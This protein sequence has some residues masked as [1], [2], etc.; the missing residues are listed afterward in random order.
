MALCSVSVL[1]VV[2]V[3]C[4]STS[5]RSH[6]IRWAS[7]F[8]FTATETAAAK[9]TRVH[10]ATG[11]ILFSARKPRNHVQ[12]LG[13]SEYVLSSLRFHTYH[14]IA[15][16]KFVKCLKH[17]VRL[18]Y[19]RNKQIIPVLRHRLHRQFSHLVATCHR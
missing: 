10:I 7:S 12:S 8:P 14:I 1:T 11:I 13:V 16:S 3:D 17:P 5:Y 18:T 2:V 6:R 4:R 9:G 15:A 19:Y